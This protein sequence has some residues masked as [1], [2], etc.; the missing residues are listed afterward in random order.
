[1]FKINDRALS[2]LKP[3]FERAV[4]VLPQAHAEAQVEG[5]GHLHQAMSDA[6]QSEGLPTD[7]LAV[8]NGYIGIS[9][10]PEGDRLADS[11]FGTPNRPADPVLRHAHRKALP[12]AS[13][14]YE[15]SLRSK[16]GLR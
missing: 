15:A 7:P 5:L 14:V 3:H 2:P 6:A 4:K 16:I 12:E 8:Y 11:E 1:M 13:A 9:K 10:T